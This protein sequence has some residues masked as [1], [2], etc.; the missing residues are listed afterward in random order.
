MNIKKIIIFLFLFFLLFS[1]IKK[2]SDTR[3]SPVTEATI[4]YLSGQV[5][6][7]NEEAEIGDTVANKSTIV[8][9]DDGTCDI[10]FDTKNIIKVMNNTI[11]ELDFS[12][13]QKSVT[14]K[15]GAL[16][17]V[18]KKLAVLTDSDSFTI[19][20]STAILGVRGTSFF[21]KADAD[22]TYVCVCNGILTVMDENK[23]N[24]EEIS[25]KHHLARLFTKSEEGTVM[26]PAAMLY[27]TDED[28]E[29]V[30]EKIGYEINW[31]KI[32]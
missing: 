6:V 31:E 11:F 16:T 1:C 23:N 5:S 13:V 7:N 19:Q 18:L 14:L 25:A 2:S 29:K 20:T 8:T 26:V 30:A 28:I 12:G 9:G 27:H 21:V 3:T 32:E 4:E 24:P 10:I 15:Q 22:S 17:N